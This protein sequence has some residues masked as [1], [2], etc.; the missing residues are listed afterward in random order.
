MV[1]NNS[2]TC[3]FEIHV[4]CALHFYDPLI[5]MAKLFPSAAPNSPP[6]TL[7]VTL[8]EM[9]SHKSYIYLHKLPST[10]S[11]QVKMCL[12]LWKHPMTLIYDRLAY[13]I[14]IHNHLCM[15]V[16]HIVVYIQYVSVSFEYFTMKIQTLSQNHLLD[17]QRCTLT[18]R[19]INYTIADHSNYSTIKF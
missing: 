15:I 18:T 11:V 3:T 10:A 14:N 5:R 1:E 2:Q 19:Q 17:N 12:N 16:Y 7:A 9:C 4:S 8:A 6:I 13:S